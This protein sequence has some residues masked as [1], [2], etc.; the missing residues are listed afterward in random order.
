MRRRALIGTG[1]GLAL[2][3]GQAT[4]QMITTGS[5]GVS[6]TGA[7]TYSIPIGVPPG[8]AGIEPKLALNY[9]SQAGNGLLGMGWS[10]SGLSGVTRCPRTYAQDGSRGATNFDANDRFCLDGQR[11]IAIS[12]AYG[13]NG[14]EY[15]TELESF[16]KI[17]S[18]GT[19]GSGP[20]YFVV[21]SKAGLTMEYGNTADS[22][23][24]AQGKASVRLWAINRVTDSKSNSM[25]MT[26]WKSADAA[27]HVPTKISWG[28]NI[29]KATPDIASVQLEYDVARPDYESGYLAG[30][31]ADTQHRLL[32]VKSYVGTSLVKDYRVAY[33]QSP[34]SKRTRISSITECDAIGTCLPPTSITYPAATSFNFNGAGTGLWSGNGTTAG[35]ESN[36]TADFNSDGFS[37]IATYTGAAGIWNVCLS[38]AVGLNCS[39]W[40]GH[41]GGTSNNV[42]GDFNGD[43]L[44]DL[45]GYTGSG[46]TWR[47]CL[48]TGSGFN[49][50]FWSIHAGG[51]TNNVTGDFDGDGRTD[52]ATYNGNG[53]WQVCLSSGSAF[54]C[55]NWPGHEG[56]IT[57][58]LVA[59]FN[60]DGKS[61]LATY[62]VNGIWQI[63][64]SSGSGFSCNN[65]NAHPGGMSN[66]IVGDFNGD[67]LSDLAA[68]GGGTTWTVCLSTGTGFTCNPW[69]GAAASVANTFTGDF[70]G[71]GKTDTAAYAGGT[72]WNVCLSSGRGFSCSLWAG[73]A[74]GVANNVRGDFNGDGRADIA[75]YS[76]TAWNVTLSGAASTDTAQS[77]V[78]GTGS[79]VTFTHYPL[80]QMAAGRYYKEVTPVYPNVFVSSPMPIVAVAEVSNGIGGNR[81]SDY[82]YGTGLADVRGRGFLGFAW[83]QTQDANTGI[84]V[85]TAY[86]QDFP[87]IGMAYQ[88]GR[89]DRAWQLLAFNSNYFACRDPVTGTNCVVAPGLRYFVYQWQNLQ[90]NWE[91]SYPG[92]PGPKLPT[93]ATN[94]EYDLWGNAVSVVVR[95]LGPAWEETG[96]NK[97]TINTF[98]PPDL[99]NWIHGRLLKST[100]TSTAP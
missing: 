99:A 29:Q 72:N 41:E 62:T 36:I 48:S 50:Q 87:Y 98:A 89:W 76:G 92:I 70:N 20:A 68:Y 81:R 57:N 85:R 32:R 9:N 10:L 39:H 63:C 25:S 75:S 93:T 19:A 54:S 49:C 77:I 51:S 24:E 84:I 60:G 11:L 13:A 38:T 2:L 44:T 5:F 61:D 4:A 96:Y 26:Y 45:A 80:P 33:S 66:N 47:V 97:T 78:S 43:G 46:T 31:R 23:V 30:S 15:R 12:G 79:A 100:V 35:E 91:L 58:N 7:A 86:H 6:E 82:W 1:F 95:T 16:S 65:V 8:V 55:S 22:R 21:K 90:E 27:L 59:D 53:A 83:V 37:D 14:T 94:T 42:V 67:G 34:G 71:D 69:T 56:G 74:G 73:H 28:A 52:M 18:Y 88:I 40:T 64:L 17:V 3:F